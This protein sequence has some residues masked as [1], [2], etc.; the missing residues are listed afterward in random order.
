[1]RAYLIYQSRI[2]PIEGE[3]VTLGRKLDNDI[4]LSSNRVS[5]HH[6]QIAFE[7]EAY[8]LH[9]LD[10]SSGSYVNGQRITYP[11]RLSSGDT[12]SLADIEI[13][14][15]LREEDLE[16]STKKRTSKL[17]TSKPDGKIDQSIE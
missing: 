13:E 15:I 4:V 8:F 1:M 14:F 12:I 5:R 17:D 2:L 3:K 10:S 7:R 9:D 11:T 16:G 6:A